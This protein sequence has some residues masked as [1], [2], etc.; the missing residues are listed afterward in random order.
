MR[1]GAW[2]SIEN[3]VDGLGGIGGGAGVTEGEVMDDAPDSNG[4]ASLLLDSS[5]TTSRC[6]TGCERLIV[7]Y[8]RLTMHLGQTAGSA[9]VVGRQL[10]GDRFRLPLHI[11][12]RV[13][14][15]AHWMKRK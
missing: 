15:T 11:A 4:V 5:S 9:I 1:P 12:Q 13:S 8:R 2:E 7:G 3:V 14:I 10:L 6:S